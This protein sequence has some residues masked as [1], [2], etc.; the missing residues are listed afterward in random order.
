MRLSAK[1]VLTGLSASCV[2]FQPNLS[3]QTIVENGTGTVFRLGTD[4]KL[5][6]SKDA[7]GNRLPDFSFVGYH[8]GEKA[9]PNVPIKITIEPVEGDNTQHIQDAL[10]RLGKL[11]IGKDGFRGALLLKRGV[12]RVDGRLIMSDSGSVLR[13]E[14][15]GPN[16]T[17]II[18]TGYDDKKYQRPLITVAPRKNTSA[19]S[20]QYRSSQ[21]VPEMVVTA[22]KSAITDT[23]VPIGARSSSC[24]RSRIC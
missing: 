24:C 8:S 12:Y 22:S 20:T 18:A 3:A 23:Y 19:E 4:E 13:G 16:G 5:D 7:N 2:L 9:I 21:T 17:I 10:D 15:S 14:G 11:P 1:I 6:Y